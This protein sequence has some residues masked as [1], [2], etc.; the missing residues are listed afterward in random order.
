M[1]TFLP[2]PPAT[3][4]IF[5]LEF[6]DNLETKWFFHTRCIPKLIASFITSYELATL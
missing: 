2:V 3:S 5:I 1:I 4:S 6:G